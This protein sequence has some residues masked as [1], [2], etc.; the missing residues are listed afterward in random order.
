MLRK[1]AITIDTYDVSVIDAPAL[2]D[3]T[4]GFIVKGHQASPKE[5]VLMPEF[6]LHVNV[7]TMIDKHKLRFPRGQAS[8]KD[9]TWMRVRVNVSKNVNLGREE[10]Y[11]LGHDGF[12]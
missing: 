6:W 12:Q 11:H 8:D 5:A 4:N 3:F 9:I 2:D 10:V 1:W 7:Q